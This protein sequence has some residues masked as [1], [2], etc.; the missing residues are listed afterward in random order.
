MDM[1]VRRAWWN[2]FFTVIPNT[3]SVPSFD[4]FVVQTTSHTTKMRS[5][6]IQLTVF[7]V[8]A[9]A[10]ESAGHY[11]YAI[12]IADGLMVASHLLWHVRTVGSKV[13]FLPT[14][15]STDC[16]GH[17]EALF[18][19]SSEWKVFDPFHLNTT[20]SSYCTMGISTYASRVVKLLR[21]LPK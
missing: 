11:D 1:Y 2:T 20:Q 15:L 18:G 16:C 21:Y 8:R 12:S 5:K 10:W 9:T 6:N 7:P 4:T 3:H 14:E 13:P 17:T 19:N